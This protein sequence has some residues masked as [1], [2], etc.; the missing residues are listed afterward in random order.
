MAIGQPTRHVLRSV[1]N[2]VPVRIAIVNTTALAV[3]HFI[4]LFK[5]E[6]TLSE[7]CYLTLTISFSIIS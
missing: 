5:S 7:V 3:L 4:M 2:A 1:P 6:V